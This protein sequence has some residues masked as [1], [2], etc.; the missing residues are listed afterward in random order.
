MPV[1]VN[2]VPGDV[3]AGRISDPIVRAERLILEAQTAKSL[4]VEEILSGKV[5]EASSRLKGT[6]A[7]LRREASLIPV[8]DE[9][10]AESLALIKTEADEIDVL[11]QT[12]EEQD[13]MYS[14]KRMTESFSRKTRAR[15]VRNQPEDPSID[16]DT[17][18]N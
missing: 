5:K 17:Y 2:V 14:S 13:V 3:A 4:A 9:R 11:A 15:N 16:P 18:L 10:S 8:T 1:N 6:A 7:N 12:A